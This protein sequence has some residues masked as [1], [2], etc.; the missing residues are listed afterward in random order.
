MSKWGSVQFYHKALNTANWDV[1]KSTIAIEV[2]S[3]GVFMKEILNSLNGVTPNVITLKVGVAT[4]SHK[5]AYDHR[6]GREISFSR[7]QPEDFVIIGINM[8]RVG[9][10]SVILQSLKTSITISLTTN[11]ES[12]PHLISARVRRKVEN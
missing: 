9:K 12:I 5:D 8:N 6:V 2:P 7:L 11:K 4:L 1:K 3:S 10:A